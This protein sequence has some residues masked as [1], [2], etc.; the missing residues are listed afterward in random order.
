MKLPTSKVSLFIYILTSTFMYIGVIKRNWKS[1]ICDNYYLNHDTY[2]NITVKTL[3][4]KTLFLVSANIKTH[5][6][7]LNYDLTTIDDILAK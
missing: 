2:K 1:Y 4:Y 5:C 7:F 6:D 3:Q